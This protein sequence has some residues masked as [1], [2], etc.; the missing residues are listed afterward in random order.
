MYVVHL[1]L[2]SAFLCTCYDK[3]RSAKS[4]RQIGNENKGVR[5]TILIKLTLQEIFGNRC[6]EFIYQAW[7]LKSESTAQEWKLKTF[8]ETERRRIWF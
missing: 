2:E 3:R 4:L 6:G 8:K 1:K 5:D 7:A